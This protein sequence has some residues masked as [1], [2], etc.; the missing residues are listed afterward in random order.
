MNSAV[1]IPNPFRSAIVADPWNWDVVDVAEIHGDAFD[2]CRRALEF[3]RSQ[4][5]STSVLFYGEAGSGK[6]HLL[7]RLQAYLA[8]L[9]TIYGPA[10]PAVFVSVRLQTSPQMIWRHLRNRFGEDLLRPTTDG[11][12]Q[13]ERI[14][15]PRIRDLC[16]EIGEP[17]AWLERLQSRIRTSPDAVEE[18]E[19][20]LDRLDQQLLINDRD[21]LTVIR[22]LLLGRHRRDARAWLRG[23]SLPEAALS[24]IEVINDHDNLA[25][26]RARRIVLSL[27]RLTGP[28]MPLVFCFDQVEALQSHP[29]DLEG[30]LKFGQMASYLHDSTK[31]LLIISC[32]LTQ[33]YLKLDQLLISSDRDRLVESGSR[34]LAPL[35][36]DQAE[37]LVE[38]RLNSS[39]ELSHLR[40]AKPG[41]FWPLRRTDIREA[42]RRNKYTPRELLSFCAEKFEAAL[43]PE[44]LKTR[45][46][47]ADFLAGAVEERLDRAA[48]AASTEI[49]D[50]ILTHGLPLLLRLIDQNWELRATA[51][52]GDADLVFENPRSRISICLCNHRNMTN[53]AGRLRRLRDQRTEQ[54]LEETTH[55]KF[56]LIRDARFPIAASAKKTRE[57]RE[58]LVAQGFQWVSASAAMLAALHALR[59]LLSDAKAG[60]LSHGGETVSPAIV[61][62]WLG[63]NLDTRLRPLRELLDN[64]LPE[65][66]TSP[67]QTV[68]DDDFNLCEDI[69]E[70]LHNHH[71]VSVADAACKLD[72]S[73]DEIRDCARRYP[74]RFGLLNGPPAVI[75]QPTMQAVDDGEVFSF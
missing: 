70:L 58:K 62:E 24:R 14:L 49:T 20:A 18:M 36:P 59:E 12:S 8:G 51:S 13:L 73:E 68:R 46:P 48:A 35:L 5:L 17:R 23:E 40:R 30:L 54:V 2:L 41:R 64:L 61:Q 45:P 38:A 42:L 67:D 65:T 74:E 6:T 55:E 47:L 34:L 71:L 16:P 50:Q 37:R 53:L 31:N 11:R 25:E 10:P 69:G 39:P 21:L 22:H 9:V 57:H 33:F 44:L 3:V 66:M 7:A 15:L 52:L 1:S 26:D 28:E 4:N 56:I 19:E 29:D 63:A 75:F 60:D 32:I 43:R 27:T 72:R